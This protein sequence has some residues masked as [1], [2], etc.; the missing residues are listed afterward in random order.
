MFVTVIALK[1]ALLVSQLSF[2]YAPAN[3][4]WTVAKIAAATRDV[5]TADPSAD[6]R[7]SAAI[8]ATVELSS[9]G[10]YRLAAPGRYLVRLLFRIT[11][12]G[13]TLG[14]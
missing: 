6:G 12:G 5:R 8:F 4:S 10:A 2:G 3:G 7:R 13:I 1:Y 11:V 14:G 9:A